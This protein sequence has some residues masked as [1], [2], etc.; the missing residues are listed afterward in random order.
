MTDNC[1]SKLLLPLGP[2]GQQRRWQDGI[3]FFLLSFSTDSLPSSPL[4]LGN[5]PHTHLLVG[6]AWPCEPLHPA[7]L[8]L[9][10]QGLPRVPSRFGGS[11]LLFCEHRALLGW[12]S[13][14]MGTERQQ[15]LAEIWSPVSSVC[16]LEQQ[17]VKTGL[18]GV[19][20]LALQGCSVELE[21]W[22]GRFTLSLAASTSMK[23]LL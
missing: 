8:P 6:A 20:A 2:W 11:F 7:A 14:T 3:C 5:E 13:V 21:C 16:V 12:A 23:C 9:V 4:L 15:T 17:H 18:P 19:L 1:E 10:G 22:E